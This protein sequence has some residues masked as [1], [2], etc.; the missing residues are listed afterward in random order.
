M[1]LFVSNVAFAQ[2]ERE[3]KY[4]VGIQSSFP[5]W[6]I[7]GMVDVAPKIS[8]QGILGIVG[9]LR[10]YAGRGIYRFKKEPHWNTYGYGMIGAWSYPWYEREDWRIEEKT[11]TAIGFGAGAG[12]EYNWQALTPNLP[13]LWWNLE[14]GMGRVEFEEAG[15]GFATFMFGGGVHYRF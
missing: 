9:D 7:S 12:I 2:E 8:V 5:A 1:L 14:A 11:E 10:T 13:P 4:G 3:T 15:Y 6:G